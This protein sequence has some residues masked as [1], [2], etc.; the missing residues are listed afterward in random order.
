MREQ[1]A[2]LLESIHFSGPNAT[3]MTP[4]LMNQCASTGDIPDFALDDTTSS[5]NSSRARSSV[6]IKLDYSESGTVGDGESS[7]RRALS[8]E[9]WSRLEPM[10]NITE[11]IVVV[12]NGG[13]GGGASGD[14]KRTE[15]LD[16]RLS[17]AVQF[18]EAVGE[19]PPSLVDDLRIIKEDHSDVGSAHEDDDDDDD[20][21]TTILLERRDSAHHSVN[22]ASESDHSSSQLLVD[23]PT[24]PETP[25]VRPPKTRP[26]W[27]FQVV[28]T[29]RGFMDKLP[30]DGSSSQTFVYKGIQANPPEITTHGTNRG[31]YAQL[32]RKAW[33]EVSDKYHRYGKN[34]RLY[35]RYWESLGFPTN[36]FFDW[37]DSKG[38]AA[39]QPLP[40]LQDC[41]RSQL[42]ADTVL[43]I[44]NPSVTAGYA[45]KF[46]PSEFG[47]GYVT[48]VDGDPV[49]TGPDG[50]IFVLR[51][52]VM[53]GAQKITSVSGHSKQRFHH[54][55]FF[56]GKAV[57][58]AGVFITDDDGILTQL[59]PH[60]GHYRPGEA[61]MQRMLF[62]IHNQGIDLR[63]FEVDTQ[64]ILHV[65][66]DGTE[67]IEKKKKIESL[68]L[69]PAVL[70]ACYLA[71]KARL[72]GEGVFAR[73]HQIR[74]VEATS[75]REALNL[76]DNGGNN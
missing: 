48:D 32:H 5:S 18:A 70:V 17:E 6:S 10:D 20:D 19:L 76:I 65:A 60:S 8:G 64:Q 55:T 43:Y 27:P 22:L 54:S 21:A 11:E 52:N 44:T 14:L 53:Y 24:V 46:A 73:I 47:Q 59:F 61:D 1:D 75:V 72:V 66:R 9:V 38:E 26:Q 25:E 7:R 12:D 16:R 58:A 40:E 28:G 15:S 41:P 34:L 63:T 13:G 71:H 74:K 4:L 49:Q 31:N 56:G 68:N 23:V 51:D 33:L 37:L 57:S 2:E 35:Y 39:G 42:D 67:K 36:M 69:Q 62:Y 30:D 29:K 3:G 45:L 50:W